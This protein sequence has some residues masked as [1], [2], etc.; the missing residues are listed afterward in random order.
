MA[1]TKRYFQEAPDDGW[2]DTPSPE[3]SF[4]RTACIMRHISIT[5]ANTTQILNT[6]EPLDLYR[7]AKANGCQ[8][9]FTSWGR[10]TFYI[11]GKDAA[12]MT[13]AGSILRLIPGVDLTIPEQELIPGANA[14]NM[15]FK[16]DADFS[17]PNTYPPNFRNVA[18]WILFEYVGVATITPGQCQ[19]DMNPLGN[20]AAMKSAPVVSS[21]AIEA[22]PATV[23]GSGWWDKIK[24][25][26]SKVN[27]WAKSTGIVG[28]ALSYIPEYGTA[29]SNAAKAL[30][31][32]YKRGR[33]E[34]YDG[35]AVMGMGDFC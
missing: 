13:G 14:N 3:F 10:D 24:S 17:V 23:E 2:S 8:D 30:G 11:P 31:Y 4:N 19:I 25:A 12:V 6:A 7:I 27:N 26:L 32:G 20:G 28:K 35:G 1:P 33:T 21:N 15:V 34:D 5:M 22:A 16:V 9:S 18:L 29:L